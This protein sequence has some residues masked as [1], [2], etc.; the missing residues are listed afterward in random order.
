MIEG[1]LGEAHSA[2]KY[3]PKRS[4]DTVPLCPVWAPHR[5]PEDAD[6]IA[7]GQAMRAGSS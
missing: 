2:R 4:S 5:V 6:L 7:A 1:A 3:E